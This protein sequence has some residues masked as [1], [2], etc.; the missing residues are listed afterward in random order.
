MRQCSCFST[1]L[2]LLVLQCFYAARPV[3]AYS[4]SSSDNVVVYWGQSSAG[5]QQRLSDYCQSDSVDIVVLSFLM[6]FYA[7]DGL[8]E[9]NFA[10]ACSDTFPG[11]TLLKCDQIAEDIQTCQA[12]GKKVLLSLGGAAGSY[13]FSSDSEGSSFATT[14]WNMFGGGTSDYRP[15]GSAVVDGFDLDIENANSIGYAAFVEQMRSLYGGGNYYIS[16]APQCPFPDASIG[17]ALN[18]AWFDFV[19]IQFYNN[20]CGVNNPSQFNYDSDWQAWVSSTALNKN[21]KLYVGVPGSSSAAGSGYTTPSGLL[22]IM[23]SISDKSSLGGIMIWD[24]SQAFTN[25]VDSSLFIDGIKTM[26][27]QIGSSPSSSSQSAASSVSSSVVAATSSEAAVTFESLSISQAAQNLYVDSATSSEAMPDPTTLSVAE[28]TTSSVST[29]G[30]PS[31]SVVEVSTSSF[32]PSTSSVADLSSSSDVAVSSSTSEV[33]LS[34]TTTV[35]QSNRYTATEI[36]YVTVTVYPG[37]ITSTYTSVSTMQATSESAT[38]SEPAS[39]SLVASAVESAAGQASVVVDASTPSSS[40]ADSSNTA[41]CS[42]LTGVELANC[43]NAYF[44]TLSASSTCTDGAIAC[45]EGFFA[46]C[47]GSSWVTFSCPSGTVCT[48]LPNGDTAYA[49]VTCDTEDDI[50]R[51]FGTSSSKKIRRRNVTESEE[52]ERRSMV[53]R[54]HRHHAH[55]RR[56]TF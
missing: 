19:F 41:D 15:F 40:S 30:L 2:I 6:T 20:Y 52:L 48:A 8:P 24:A 54:A 45:V 34:F 5:S 43:E 55:R 38:L 22:D 39:S 47:D 29:I 17:D 27:G 33:P 31:S 7:A 21:V 35:T 18:N 36:Q 23:N 51:I 25:T 44:A 42:S 49:I 14:L 3:D 32:E 50:S 13:G 46:K 11:T 1:L 12:E 26:L 9:V 37:D 4:D 28:P 56:S 53:R 16:G 10:N